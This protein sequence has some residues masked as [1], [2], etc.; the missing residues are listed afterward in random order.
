MARPI[1]LEVAPRDPREELRVKLEQAPIDHAQAL[2]AGYEVL[3]L[4]HERGILDILRGMLAARD[5]LLDTLVAEVDKPAVIR[6]VR[7][8]FFWRRTLGQ[9]EPSSFTTIFKAI[10]E[11]LARATAPRDQPPNLFGLARRAVSKDSLRGLA[12]GIDFLET[13]GRQLNAV[14]E[15][16]PNA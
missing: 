11:G 12:A 14:D 10:P 15:K 8:L 2:L 1:A 6:A 9:L 16:R 13:F 7:N 4:L 5:E 3:Q